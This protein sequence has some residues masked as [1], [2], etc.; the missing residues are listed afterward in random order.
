MEREWQR[1]KRTLSES[2]EVRKVFL[3]VLRMR[4]NLAERAPNFGA[5]MSLATLGHSLNHA[6]ALANLCSAK[7]SFHP[8][9]CIL[10]TTR[11][12]FLG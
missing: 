9:R 6:L 4:S 5:K 2:E 1:Y 8:T 11:E 10:T 7:S 12:Q 3:S